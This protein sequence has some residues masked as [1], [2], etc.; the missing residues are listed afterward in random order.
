MSLLKLKAKVL[1]VSEE[2]MESDEKYD[3]GNIARSKE[4]VWRN[5]A[6]PIEDVYKIIEY[7]KSKSIVQMRDQERILV[8]EPFDELFNRWETLKQEAVEYAEETQTEEDLNL[9][10]DEKWEE[11]DDG[12]I[13]K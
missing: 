2:Q 5:V 13:P 10:D 1:L 3:L 8:A 7:N 6:V 9:G 11:Q 12:D 4:W